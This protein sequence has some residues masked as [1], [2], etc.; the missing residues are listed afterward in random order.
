MATLTRAVLLQVYVWLT[1]LV[2]V[3]S[4]FMRR[5]WLRANTDESTHAHW[6]RSKVLSKQNCA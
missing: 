5:A 1:V 3:L 2:C 6:L 4:V